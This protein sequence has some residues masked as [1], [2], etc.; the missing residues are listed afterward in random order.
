M[1][2]LSIRS[3]AQDNLRSLRGSTSGY[4]CSYEKDPKNFFEDT[5]SDSDE[6]DHE[7]GNESCYMAFGSQE[8]HLNPYHSNKALNINDLQNDNF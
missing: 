2:K 7:E 6:G 4:G 5:W 1:E 3:L 8:V